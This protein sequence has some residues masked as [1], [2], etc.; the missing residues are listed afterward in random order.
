MKR[1]TVGEEDFSNLLIVN[2]LSQGGY[3]LFNQH[4]VKSGERVTSTQ[5]R[6]CFAN[7]KNL[8]PSI[9]S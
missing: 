7:L 5:A 6:S 3:S 1:V 9:N 2:A 4:M 8:C